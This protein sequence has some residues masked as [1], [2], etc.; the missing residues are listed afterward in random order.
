MK[1][2]ESERGS[3]AFCEENRSYFKTWKEIYLKRGLSEEEATKRASDKHLFRYN[4]LPKT[5]SLKH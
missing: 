1:D 3:G 4:T 5:G 2:S